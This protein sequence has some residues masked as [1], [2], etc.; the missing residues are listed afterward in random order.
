[1]STNLLRRLFSLCLVLMLIAPATVSAASWK[2][3]PEHSSIQFQVRYMGLVN[4][5][6]SF[7]KFQGE[8]VL[9]EK[10]PSKSSVE[11]TIE[12]ASINTGVERRDE[13]LRTDDFFDCPKYPTIRFVSKK[14]MPA[15]KHKL[16]V[17]G[18]LTMLGQTREVVLHVE[19]PTPEI[20]DPW[21]N[22]R[23]GVTARTRINR[24]DFG[25][26][27]NQV[28]DSGGIMI[29]KIVDVIMEVELVKT[30]EEQPS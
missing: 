27:W 16:K 5:K 29:S 19:G 18:D 28:L 25:M 23:R 17:V 6:G 30:A 2:I 24:Q 12:S 20:K 15:G 21:G 22:F 13:H 11:V 4:V 10:N 1:M 14:V 8:V 26:T 3:N 7:D 9:N